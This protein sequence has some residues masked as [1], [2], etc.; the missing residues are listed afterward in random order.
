MFEAIHL[1][2]SNDIFVCVVAAPPAPSAAVGSAA[3]AAAA[4]F[5]VPPGE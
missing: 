2:H 1:F 3:A 4:D 5:A